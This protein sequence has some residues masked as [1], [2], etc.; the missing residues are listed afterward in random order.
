MERDAWGGEAGDVEGAGHGEGLKGAERGGGREREGGLRDGRG[1][2][3]S[4]ED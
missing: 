3:W 2:G 1:D 4:E